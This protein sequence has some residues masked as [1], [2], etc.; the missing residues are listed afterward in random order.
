M[1]APNFWNSTQLRILDL[2]GGSSFREWGLQK[3]FIPCV[4]PI[5]IFSSPRALQ[6]LGG[7]CAC[8]KEKAAHLMMWQCYWVRSASEKK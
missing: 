6:Y 4:A 2:T 5:L 8:K 3:P 1:L 7:R